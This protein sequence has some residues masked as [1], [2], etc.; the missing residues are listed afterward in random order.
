MSE[1]GGKAASEAPK[2]AE[3]E[4]PKTD[5]TAKKNAPKVKKQWKN[6]ALR[7]MGI[8]RFSLPSRN[9]MIFWTVLA[10]IGGGIA[11]DKYQQKQI[12]KK[13]MDQVEQYSTEVY[14]NDRIPRKLTIFIAPPPN[15]FLDESLR[16]FK[17]YIKPV[18]NASAV[19]YEVFTENRQGDIRNGVAEKIRQLRREQKKK[20]GDNASGDS[21]KTK[22]AEKKSNGSYIGSGLTWN[23]KE[24]PLDEPTKTR[25]ELYQPTDVLGLYRIVKPFDSVQ[26][27][28][29]VSPESA[30][31]VVCIGRGAY[32]EYI[33][34]VHEGLL[35]PLDKPE[36][37]VEVDAEGNKVPADFSIP[38][39]Q[40]DD[41]DKREP[42]PKP[43]ISPADYSKAELAPELNLT[44]IIR[45]D[46]NVPVLFEQPVYVFPVPNILGFLNLPRKIYRFYTKR[47][48]AEDYCERTSTIVV[49]NTSRPFE[50]RDAF[51]GKEEE[52]DWPKK[53][54]ERG[55]E[56][57]SE[58]AQELEVDERVTSRMKVFDRIVETSE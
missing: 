41:E 45:N 46:K 3:S 7:M 39:E 12:R 48:V 51:M 27:D 26:R 11:Y 37:K 5:G 40:E 18:L 10:S 28:D 17:R 16:Y 38:D 54:V 56:K 8:P 44:Q 23:K 24:D 34:G 25:Q 15:D 20:S 36:E 6:P 33:T 47:Y 31:G 53:W 29:A 19:D 32:K 58:W 49:A 9:W 43:F 55:K 2:P 50:F 52:L 35:G 57:G 42:V 30:G 4:I 13:W 14:A 22:S 1:T 21:D